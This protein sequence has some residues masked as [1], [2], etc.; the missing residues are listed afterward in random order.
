MPDIA[1]LIELLGLHDK[2]V[3]HE[4]GRPEEEV[5]LG[6][7][8]ELVGDR[9]I[10]GDV[11]LPTTRY[12]IADLVARVAQKHLK[13]PRILTI[14]GDLFNFDRFSPFSAVIQAPSWECELLAAKAL[15]KRWLET[16]DQIEMISGNHDRRLQKVL[17][18]EMSEETFSGLIY[19]NSDK[20]RLS[21]YG[22]CTI[23]SGG[24]SWRVTHPKNYSINQLVTADTLASKFQSNIISFH[25]HHLSMGWDRYKNFI[26]VNGGSLADERQIPYMTLDDN[27][28]SRSAPG[29]VMLKN[30]TPYL[31]GEPPFTDYSHWKIT[32]S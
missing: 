21:N 12:G 14:A 29:F 11:H 17:A 32:M 20:F 25:E 31:F 13:R 16:F 30:G 8:F 18:G 9:M 1:E 4:L 26:I 19:G 23:R 15:I 2:Q 6:T 10:I 3:A 22:W 28:A 27:K 5:H 7:P 24:V